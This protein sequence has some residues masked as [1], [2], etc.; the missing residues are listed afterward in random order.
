MPVD[1]PVWLDGGGYIKTTQKAQQNNS[2][3][4]FQEKKSA[5]WTILSLP[6]GNPW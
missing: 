4:S 2:M 6:A 5:D 3:L 1:D